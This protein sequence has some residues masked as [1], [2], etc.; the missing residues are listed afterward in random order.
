MEEKLVET[1][2]ISKQSCTRRSTALFYLI[3]LFRAQNRYVRT[4][5]LVR[6]F[7][8]VL[9]KMLAAEFCV[10]FP[11]VERFLRE[12]GTD[13]VVVGINDLYRERLA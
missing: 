10:H 11:Q 3:L 12:K 2:S 5:I 6:L 13:V 7:L 1:N 4:F 9:D 8:R